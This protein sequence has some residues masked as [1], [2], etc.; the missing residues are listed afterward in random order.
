MAS[1]RIG[2]TWNPQINQPLRAIALHQ[3]YQNEQRS[4]S[5]VWSTHHNL[6]T[7]GSS[8]PSW[9]ANCCIS[10]LLVAIF[11]TYLIFIGNEVKIYT[12]QPSFYRVSHTLNSSI[13]SKMYPNNFQQHSSSFFF[14]FNIEQ[15]CQFLDFP[16]SLFDL[17]SEWG[18]E[19]QFLWF[20][21]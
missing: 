14:V 12:L 5:W 21:A 15:I 13:S 7:R 3:I 11:F 2:Y 20:K 8:L 9:W 1:I 16:S 19:R 10:M 17:S 18:E 6:L 4:R